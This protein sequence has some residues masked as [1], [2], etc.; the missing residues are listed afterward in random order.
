MGLLAR[1]NIALQWRASNADRV[2]RPG[3]RRHGSDIAAPHHD[4]TGG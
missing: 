1:L 2:C 4:Q 3:R